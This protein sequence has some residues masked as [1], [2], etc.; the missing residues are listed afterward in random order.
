ML[1]IRT[2]RHP[3]LCQTIIIFSLC[4]LFRVGGLVQSMAWD[5][6]NER[7]AVLCQG[8]CT[9]FTVRQRILFLQ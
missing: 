5:Q 9:I 8:K 4:V 3:G 2:H 7:L 1:S 6:H